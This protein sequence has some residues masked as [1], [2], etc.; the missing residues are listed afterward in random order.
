VTSCRIHLTTRVADCQAA[1]ARA[2]GMIFGHAKVDLAT[3]AGH[4]VITGGT[5][6]FKGVRGTIVTQA[7]SPTSTKVTLVYHS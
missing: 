2:G 5:G 7:S 4:G 6:K 3:G 1:I